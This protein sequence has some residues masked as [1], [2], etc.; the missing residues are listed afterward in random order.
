MGILNGAS[1]GPARCWLWVVLGGLCCVGAAW[2]D[3]ATDFSFGDRV[4]GVMK[5]R[6]K[7][8]DMP[9]GPAAAA[10]GQAA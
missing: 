5:G 1:G 6:V 2:P 9:S 4:K 3:L 8:R 10:V 7:I